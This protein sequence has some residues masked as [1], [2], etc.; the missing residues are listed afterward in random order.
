MAEDRFPYNLPSRKAL[1]EL[2]RREKP[3]DNIQDDFVFFGDMF[4]GP[5]PG[6]PGRTFVEM[7]NQLTKVKRWFVY[8][9]L[10]FARVLGPNPII[11][12]VGKVT[13]ASIAKEINR[14]REMY[15]DYTDVDFGA[16]VLHVGGEPYEYILKALPGSYVYYGQAKITV[17]PI[18]VV[19]D[20]RLLED[21]T[22]RLLEDGTQRMLESAPV[23]A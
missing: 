1:V 23:P 11:T 20:V 6:T 9:R 4:F 18:P 7:E 14:S 22:E 10:D 17:N 3:N 12:V 15:L 19:D 2:A 16:D 5:V 8:R 13:P 21:G